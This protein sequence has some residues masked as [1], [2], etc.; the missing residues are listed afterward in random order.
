MFATCSSAAV[1]LSNL[2]RQ[3][4]ISETATASSASLSPAVASSHRQAS[5]SN[6]RLRNLGPAPLGSSAYNSGGEA[7]S[8][9]KQHLRAVATVATTAS[10]HKSV[11]GLGTDL[12]QGAAT[13][14]TA[15]FGRP[16][17]AAAA[18]VDAVALPS[19]AEMRQRTSKSRASTTGLGPVTAQEAATAS[20][21]AERWTRAAAA[22]GTISTS[23]AGELSSSNIEAAVPADGPG[24]ITSSVA[25]IPP[26][27]KPVHHPLMTSN[28][29][30]S[31]TDE[32]S[33]RAAAVVQQ[34]HHQAPGY[35]SNAAQ[36][37][38]VIA[39]FDMDASAAMLNPSLTAATGLPGLRDADWG[40]QPGLPMAA[41]GRVFTDA[42]RLES[43]E[44]PKP[45]V[46]LD[47]LKGNMSLSDH[48][49]AAKSL[50]GAFSGV[51]A[52]GL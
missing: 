51:K 28:A 31:A 15:G 33:S 48:L 42:G 8:P 19:Y 41:I 30:A 12:S 45:R 17:G 14:A 50:S 37:A 40:L 32:L 18:A 3:L 21:T 22:A 7:R 35:W 44:M 27:S 10:P 52:L 36:V 20:A 11:T 29:S 25:S 1:E 47:Q 5:D 39:D 23:M 43:M 24:G 38:P 34:Q 26:F 13:S 16:G 6:S 4:H 46:R 2:A 49:R 9:S